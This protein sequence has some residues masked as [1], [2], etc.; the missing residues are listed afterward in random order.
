M[1]LSIILFSVL[2]L[3]FTP[4]PFGMG[5]GTFAKDLNHKGIIAVGFGPGDGEAAHIANEYVEIKQ[6]VDFAYLICMV[7]L[8]LL[9]E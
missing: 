1:N 3:E 4:E 8:D 9:N 7:A 2:Y 6:L 5:G